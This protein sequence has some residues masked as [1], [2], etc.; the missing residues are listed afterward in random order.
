MSDDNDTQVEEEPDHIKALREQAKSG[1][2]SEA[3]ANEL[4]RKVAILEA[5]INTSTPL[6][7]MFLK[8]YDGELVSDAI[9]EA[10]SAVGLIEGQP[11]PDPAPGDPGTAEGDYAGAKKLLDGQGAAPLAEPPAKSA[12]DQAYA[13]RDAFLADGKRTEDA[14]AE[15]FRTL[16]D[17]A[18]AGDPTAMFDHDKYARDTEAY[19]ASQQLS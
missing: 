7:Q 2:A 15:G 19:M 4:E 1:K 6:G 11:D 8:S 18:A 17:R 10:A 14:V 3:K 12:S 5:G 9:K 13:A 16:I